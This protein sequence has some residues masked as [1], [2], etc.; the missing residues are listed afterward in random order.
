V[1]GPV[2]APQRTHTVRD[3]FRRTT[4]SI[5]KFPSIPRQKQPD[6][7]ASSDAAYGPPFANAR[8]D[9]R[10]PPTSMPSRNLVFSP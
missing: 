10:R 8:T 5:E 3:L 1:S 6:M 4:D 7:F 9:W 2:Q